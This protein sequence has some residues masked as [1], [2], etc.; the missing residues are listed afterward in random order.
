M[1][2]AE[3]LVCCRRRAFGRYPAG[4][5]RAGCRSRPAG[6]WCAFDEGVMAEGDEQAL[7][8]QEKFDRLDVARAC[9]ATS[10]TMSKRSGMLLRRSWYRRCWSSWRLNNGWA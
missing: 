3:P 2:R 5:A 10:M 4:L 1:A 9:T 8:T 7:I 6:P